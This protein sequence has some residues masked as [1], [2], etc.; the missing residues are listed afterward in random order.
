M[1]EYIYTSSS[2]EPLANERG[3]ISLA[4]KEIVRCRDCVFEGRSSW[5]TVRFP[6][7][8]RNAYEV[9]TDDDGFCAWGKR[10]ENTY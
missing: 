7:C 9:M 10:K 5:G 6:T 1:G 8:K 4:R 2:G 3:E